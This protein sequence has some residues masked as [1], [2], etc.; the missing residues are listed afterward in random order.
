M[1]L[2]TQLV[3]DPWCSSGGLAEDGTLVGTGGW[4]DGVKTVRYLKP[5]D[6]CDFKEYQ[7]AL[8]DPRWYLSSLYMY[9][10]NII[11]QRMKYLEYTQESI[12]S[13]VRACSIFRMQYNILKPT[14]LNYITF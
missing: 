6:T 10:C 8:A 9:I 7:T 1:I 14:F 5:C 2:V 12:F 11:F 13:T 4:D 3:Y